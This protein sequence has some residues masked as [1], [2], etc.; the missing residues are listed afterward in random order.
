M[1]LDSAESIIEDQHISTHGSMQYA[2]LLAA[3]MFS[4]RLLM[5]SLT[6]RIDPV[7][8]IASCVASLK[9]RR[10]QEL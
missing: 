4:T 5:T 3:D 7:C 8:K 6:P 10:T 9:L 1:S 2:I